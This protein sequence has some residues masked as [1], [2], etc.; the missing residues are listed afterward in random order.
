MKQV[1]DSKKRKSLLKG[2]HHLAS[3]KPIANICVNGKRKTRTVDTLEEVIIERQKM[4]S[5]DVPTS[6]TKDPDDTSGWTLKQVYDR[7]KSLY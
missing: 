5:N 7:T 6:F 2:T 3:G 1:I 4:L